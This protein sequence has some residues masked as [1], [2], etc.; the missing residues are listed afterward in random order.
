LWFGNFSH[1]QK[2]IEKKVTIFLKKIFILIDMF[3]RATC[4]FP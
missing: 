1:A 2:K 3:M 4:S